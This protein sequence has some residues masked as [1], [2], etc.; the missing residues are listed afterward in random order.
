MPLTTAARAPALALLI[1]CLLA[2]AAGAQ[3]VSAAFN[4]I[5]IEQKLGAV[6][7][8]DTAFTGEEGQRVTLRQVV[9]AP[10]IL[11]LVYYQCPNVC[12]LLLTGLA[13]VLGPLSAVPGVEYNVVTISIDPK[14]TPEIARISKRRSL[15][16]IQK[17]FPP[18]SWRFLTGDEQAID[19]V[20]DAVGF[21]YV[22]NGDGFD[23]PVALIILSPQGKIVR[24]MMGADFLAADLQL[25]LM[26]A[27][28]GAIGPTIAKLARICF[29]VDPSSHKLVFQITKVMATITLVVAGGFVAWLVVSGRRRKRRLMHGNDSSDT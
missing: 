19:Q 5:G 8:L 25:S 20:A 27:Q 22:R 2:N 9:T 14:E 15:Q 29:R 12:D 11:A 24:Y 28:K 6:V 17:P 18:D 13:G 1:L 10:T 7:P 16:T 26:E 21:R 3:P 4:D 23:H